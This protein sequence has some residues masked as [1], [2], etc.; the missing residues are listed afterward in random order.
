[1]LL[2]GVRSSSSVKVPS[3]PGYS[4]IFI[5]FPLN[6]NLIQ[7]YSKNPQ[8]LSYRSLRK[9][10]ESFGFC[11]SFSSSLPWAPFIDYY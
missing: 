11:L 1:M 10:P 3:N 7:S 9:Y 8:L 5:F 2:R 4:E 6:H